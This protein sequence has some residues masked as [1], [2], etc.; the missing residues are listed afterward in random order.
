MKIYSILAALMVL[1]AGAASCKKDQTPCA[2]GKHDTPP[3]PRKVR[4]ELFTKEDFSDYSKNI[5]FRIHMEGDKI[6]FDS[7]LATMKVRDIPDFDHRII[8]EKLVP[9]ND[10]S[11]LTV[12]FVYQ[13]EDVGISW[14][15]EQF[16]G[17]DT[18]K[19]LTYS[20]K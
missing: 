16:P 19:V 15:L 17:K 18:L 5:T 13:I 7:N 14:Y 12:G 3:P 20:F 11:T 8:I 10:T 2:C 9:G 4:Y 1:L 6:L